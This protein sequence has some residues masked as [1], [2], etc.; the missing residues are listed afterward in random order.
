MF[1]LGPG[2]LVSMKPELKMSFIQTEPETTGIRH[3][4]QDASRAVSIQVLI[5]T[6]DVKVPFIKVLLEAKK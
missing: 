2:T 4:T 3:L 5:T 6:P 1:H